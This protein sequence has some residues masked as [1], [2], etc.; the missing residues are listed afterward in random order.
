[1]EFILFMTRNNTSTIPIVISALG[2]SIAALGLCYQLWNF[3]T[4]QSKQNELKNRESYYQPLALEFGFSDK[5]FDIPNLT[6]SLS[7]KD[8]PK[9]KLEFYQGFP[10][11]N[12]SF[13][14]S[15]EAE[16]VLYTEVKHD[17]EEFIDTQK[18]QSSSGMTLTIDPAFPITDES[19]TL[20]YSVTFHLITDFTQ[21]KQLFMVMYVL[22]K[23]VAGFI[24]SSVLNGYIFDS[25]YVLLKDVSE[26]TFM[27]DYG[28][29]SD[30]EK[31]ESSKIVMKYLPVYLDLLNKV[32]DL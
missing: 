16:M 27:E 25:D 2:V 10:I 22:P 23:P 11:E 13:Y 24:E 6:E 3:T 9:L 28:R 7:I 12:K 29:L 21:Q 14:A 1:M 26:W 4:T 19:D 5:T 30:T 20:L 31:T 17:F 8:I 18:E 32:K 15:S